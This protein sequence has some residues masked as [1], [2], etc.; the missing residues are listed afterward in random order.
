MIGMGVGLAILAWMGVAG[1]VALRGR[2]EVAIPDEPEG[3]MD[4]DLKY[5][6]AETDLF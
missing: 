5:H 1:A 6:E 3:F 4:D 2:G